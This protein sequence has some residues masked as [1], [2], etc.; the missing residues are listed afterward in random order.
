MRYNH[1]ALSSSVSTKN[2]A[3]KKVQPSPK[4]EFEVDFQVQSIDNHSEVGKFII[5]QL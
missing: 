3:C 2:N 1:R 4:Q 5:S